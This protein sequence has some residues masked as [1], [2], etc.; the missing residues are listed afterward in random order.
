MFAR[1]KDSCNSVSSWTIFES[2][3][4]ALDATRKSSRL[5]GVITR[6]PAVTNLD[7]LRY[8]SADDTTGADKRACYVQ[9]CE[10]CRS[11]GESSDVVTIMKPKKTSAEVDGMS[12]VAIENRLAH[13]AK[14]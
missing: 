1:E 3:R 9:P 8:P 10:S 4:R 2:V 6:V 12:V 7:R 13:E 5:C 14:C 11:T